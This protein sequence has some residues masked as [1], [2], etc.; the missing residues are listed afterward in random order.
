MDNGFYGL[1]NNV[2]MRTSKNPDHEIDWSEMVG[3]DRTK[4]QMTE[5]VSRLKVPR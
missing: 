1:K 4:K 2:L 3:V 5:I